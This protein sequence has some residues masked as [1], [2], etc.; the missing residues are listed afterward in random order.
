MGGSQQQRAGGSCSTLPPRPPCLPPPHHHGPIGRQGRNLDQRDCEGQLL[1]LQIV[2]LSES[3]VVEGVLKLIVQDE[4][5]GKEF[6]EGA[7]RLGGTTDG[8]QAAD[9]EPGEHQ[10]QSLQRGSFSTQGNWF[11]TKMPLFFQGSCKAAVLQLHCSKA[12]CSV[13]RYW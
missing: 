7:G 2:N 6:D 11:V 13:A 1:L 10:S 12:C 4:F 3:E 9:R 8:V 5:G